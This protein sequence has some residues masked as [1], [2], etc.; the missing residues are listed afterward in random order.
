MLLEDEKYVVKWLSQYGT[1]PRKQIVQM[2]QKPPDTAKK[3]INKTA[4]QNIGNRRR[5]LSG[6]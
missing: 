1:L 6:T 3:I 4:A 5:I 2:L